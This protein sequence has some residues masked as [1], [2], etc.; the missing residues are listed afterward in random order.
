MQLPSRAVVPQ[1]RAEV[2]RLPR[3]DDEI[4]RIE[5]AS[6]FLYFCLLCLVATS[7]SFLSIHTTFIITLLYRNRKVMFL[8]LSTELSIV[9]Y[10][11]RV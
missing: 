3:L 4:I 9:C 10:D 1:T 2:I 8:M 11:A 5:H 6:F 7:C